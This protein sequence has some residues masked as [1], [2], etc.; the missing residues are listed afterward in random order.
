[1]Q[2]EMIHTRTDAAF[3]PG[4][5][6]KHLFW[7]CLGRVQECVGLGRGLSN[8]ILTDGNFQRHFPAFSL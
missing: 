2:K 4:R 6:S 8:V 3:V 5:A 1:M 7:L